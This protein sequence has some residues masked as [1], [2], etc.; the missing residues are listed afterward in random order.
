MKAIFNFRK[1]LTY[2]KIRLYKVH[3]LLVYYFIMIHLCN[4]D[5]SLFENDFRKMKIKKSLPKKNMKLSCQAKM[6]FERSSNPYYKGKVYSI[7]IYFLPIV[8]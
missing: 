6:L 5:L 4:S 7:L 2:N 1:I 8:L 3:I